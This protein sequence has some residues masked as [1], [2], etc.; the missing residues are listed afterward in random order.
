MGERVVYSYKRLFEVRLLHHYWLDE[1]GTLFDKLPTQAEKDARLQDY[2]RRPIFEVRPTPAT[3]TLLAGKRCIFKETAPGFVVAAPADVQI[4][5]DTALQFVLSIKDARFY[6]Y[7][8]LTLRSQ[9]IHEFFNEVDKQVY[10]YKE[11]VAVLSNLKGATRGSGSTKELYLSQES[12]ALASSD[13]V[14]SLV[15]S[16]NALLQLT[17]DGPSA[18]TQQLS[19]QA[20]DWPVFVHQGD[21][22]AIVAPTGLTGVPARGIRL[23]DEVVDDVY[24]LLS[25]TAEHPDDADFS[26]VGTTGGP[27]TTPPVYQVRF[28]NRSTFWRYLNKVSGAEDSIESTALPLTYF[29]NSGTKQKPSGSLIKPEMTAGKITRL[30]SEVYI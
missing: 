25:L 4:A 30:L 20:S 14:E 29:G 2:D 12:P 24:A 13:Q 19:A 17:S 5:E 11:N 7:T 9:K 26:Y 22:P 6:T 21:V 10:R 27:K 1:G 15:L 18:T 8:A 23:S 16:S 3:E 28:K